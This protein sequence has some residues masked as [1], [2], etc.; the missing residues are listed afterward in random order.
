MAGQVKDF[1]LAL[2]YR[3]AAKDFMHRHGFAMNRAALVQ[4]LNCRP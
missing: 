3:L 4:M 1:N 2:P